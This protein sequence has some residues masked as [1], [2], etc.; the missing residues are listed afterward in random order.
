M[1]E[2]QGYMISDKEIIDVMTANGFVPSMAFAVWYVPGAGINITSAEVL[3]CLTVE[4]LDEL[5]LRAL[6]AN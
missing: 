5:C 3:N 6:G 4:E 1:G 2:G